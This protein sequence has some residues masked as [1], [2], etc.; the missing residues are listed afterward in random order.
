MA[1]V[2]QP[3]P[4]PFLRDRIILTT[5]IV[6]AMIKTAITRISPAWFKIHCICTPAFLYTRLKVLPDACCA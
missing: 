2:L 6:T 5:I 1:Q 4:Q 3:Q